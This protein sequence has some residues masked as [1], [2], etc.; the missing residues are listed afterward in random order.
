MQKID[1]KQ[2]LS[3]FDEYWSPRIVAQLNGQDV[4]LAKLSGEF[5][6]HAHDEAEELFLVIEGH[7]SIELRDG[8]VELDPGQLFVV[9][10]GVEHRPV[11]RP[12]AH[13]LL[14]EPS[15]TLNTGNAGGERTVQ[16]PER[17]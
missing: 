11:A 13:V 8:V 3:S 15:G 10:R 5:I 16:H 4:R 1:L 9:P 14:F 7:L 17:L 2:A 6:W 12:E